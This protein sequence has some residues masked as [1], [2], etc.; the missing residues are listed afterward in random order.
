MKLK[1]RKALNKSFLKIKPHRIE[2]DNFKKE[3]NTLLKKINKDEREDHNK[4]F[5]RD[6]LRET[7]YKNKFVNSK[8]TTDL[9][10][11]L[12][13]K[14]E[15]NVGV[16]IETKRPNKTSEMITLDNLNAKAM[17][18]VIL[19]YLRERIEEKN[20]D[21]K[22]IIITNTFEWFLFDAQVFEKLFYKNRKLVKDYQS[23]KNDQKVSSNT[24]HFYKEI[25][26]KYLEDVKQNL[27]FTYFDLRDYGKAI[28]N[29]NDEKN[30]IPILKIFSPQHLLKESF[31][32]DSNSLD[33][34]FYLELLHIIGLE[35]KK[36][37]SKNIIKR[38]DE[39]DRNSGSL[40]ENTIQMLETKDSLR[41]FKD[42]SNFGKDKNE[43][44]FNIALELNILW[45]NR[46][47]FLKLLE[48]QLV[49]YNKGNKDYKFLNP[50]DIQEYDDLF[51]LFH[52]VLAQKKEDR[53]NIKEKFVNIPYLNSSLFEIG[54][55]ERKTFGVDSLKDRFKLPIYKQSVFKKN[56]K[57]VQKEIP[58]LEYLFN[59][60]E[61]Y[62][63]S[64]DVGEDIA[65]EKKSIINASVLGLI[66]EKLNG[67]KEGSYFTPGF[68]TMYMAKETIRRAVIQKFEDAKGWKCE[69]LTDLKDKIG[70]NDKD[71]RTEANEIINSLKICDPAVGSGHFLVSSLN[72]ILAIKSELQI[73]CYRNGNRIKDYRLT[74]ENDELNIIDE[75]EIPFKYY[76]N[77]KGNTIESLQKLQE[78][79]FHEKETL[80]ENCL[81]G[82]DINPNS[83]NICRLRLWIELLK[84]AYYTNESGY[85]ELE[86]L[87]NIDINIKQGNS[88]ISRFDLESDISKALPTVKWKIEDYKNLVND[89]KKTNDKELKRSIKN[90]ITD[91]KS[92]ITDQLD[93]NH[94]LNTRLKRLRKQ[95][96]DRFDTIDAFESELTAK[97]KNELDKKKKKLENDLEKAAKDIIE[98]QEGEIYKQAFEWRFEF[99][100]VLDE[101]GNY[102]GFDVVIGNPP[103][104]AISKV[105]EFASHFKNSNYK[106]YKK[107][108]DIY[109]LF[110][111]RGNQILSRKGLLTFITSNSWLRVK[112]GDVLKKYFEVEMSP[113]KLLNIE[114][115]QLF[116]EATVESN[117]IILRKGSGESNFETCNLSQNYVKGSSLED[118]FEKNAYK[119]KNSKSI[120]WLIEN[121]NTLKL[122]RKIE[123]NSKFLKEYN[124]R[125]NF[126]I[127]TGFNEA[128][129]IDQKTKDALLKND[130]NNDSLIKQ[131]LRGRDISRYSFTFQN[132]YLINAHNGVKSRNLRPVD[133]SKDFPSI[134]E[135]LEKYLPEIEIRYDKGDHWTN[136]RNCA[137]LDD[138]YKPKIIWGEISDKPKFAYDEGNYYAE[139]TT[140]LMTGEKLKFLLG[141]LN[142]KVSE[143]YF[144]QISTTTGMGTNRWKK[145]K[146]ELLPIK[147]HSEDQENEIV[148]KVQNILVSKNKHKNADTSLLESEIDQLVYKLYGLTEEEIKIVEDSVK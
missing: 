76:L 131:I 144:N 58:T 128:Y 103:Y 133:I 18:E 96:H 65:E 101:K 145:Y 93:S 98:F 127:K 71:D 23:W 69:S 88:L 22:N 84:N 13:D 82:V 79:I 115:I 14:S 147:K 122:K 26:K 38:L 90:L 62:D 6:F 140:F 109:C 1:P 134:Q 110:Y 3:L 99:P 100:E 36:D 19:Y 66:F 47:L 104:F 126:G 148:N 21:I 40:L 75:D 42:P 141:I 74:V 113:L 137:Y 5:V 112:Y 73:L 80:I 67:Y 37:G 30:L 45:I 16:I 72:E 117:I 132:I 121:E 107:G 50:I 46:I 92:K 70:Y 136:L 20:D 120:E 125:I 8:G 57:L 114:D 44:L 86:T 89:Y 146:I 108:T 129:L 124:V 9:A 33:K 77:E 4:N 130:Q 28:N 119:Q 51:E 123:E 48:A 32:N 95:F 52:Q 55:L 17:H 135:Y 143:W 7:F 85:K 24:E 105:K 56:I 15:S 39:N 142:S 139:A 11:H 31:A 60:L 63:F 29:K 94:P 91:I 27:E 111:E 116:E 97:Q 138:F 64:S 12:G 2:F 49:N 87:P 41:N 35:E 34:Q 25:A 54:D 81:F 61:A 102:L 10:I 106:T 78:A 53:K 118:Y 59:F 68:I 43:Q 83:V